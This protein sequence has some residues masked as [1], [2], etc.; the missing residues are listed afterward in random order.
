MDAHAHDTIWTDAAAADVLNDR[1]RHV[2]KIAGKHIL[3]FRSDDQ[4]WACNNRCPHEG[5]PLSEGEISDG[6]ILTCNWHNWKFDLASGDTLI[7]GDKLRRYP[8]KIEDSRIWIDISDPPADQVINAALAD[9]IDCFDDHEYDRMAREVARIER[10][11]ESPLQALI[12]TVNVSHDRFEYGMTHAIAAGADWLR[13]Y[14]DNI[15]DPAKRLTAVVE[16]IGNLA[17]DSRRMPA[18][19]FSKQALPFNVDAFLSAI[20]AEDEATAIAYVR[21]G[22]AEGLSFDDLYN[23]LARAALAHY[24]DFGHSLIYVNKAREFVEHAGIEC[25]EPVLLMLVRSLVYATREDLIPEFKAYRPALEQTS[26]HKKPIDSVI[27]RTSGVPQALAQISNSNASHMETYQ[28]LMEAAAWQLL[29][30]DLTFADT[31]SGPVQDNVGWLDVTHTITFANAVRTT[32]Q[33]IPELWSAGLLQIGCFLG[34]NGKYMDQTINLDEWSVSDPLGFAGHARQECLHHGQAEYIV[35][36]HILKLSTAIQDEIEVS[37]NAPW[38]AE[39]AAGLNR[40]LNSPLRRKNPIRTANQ[41][42]DMIKREG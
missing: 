8:I 9:L 39:L 27:L 42:L 3:I 20:K 16:V 11:G 23:P 15:D 17:W 31:R 26:E 34:R 25:L 10:A 37:P 32:C 5:Y 38:A 7:G 33:A 13:I 14:K 12:H 41:A 2:L 19:P 24:Q 28:T 30:L 21:G 40:F 35:A 29:H 1:D 6:C 4:I 36:A 22:L 18:F